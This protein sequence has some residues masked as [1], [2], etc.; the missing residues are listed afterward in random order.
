MLP[1][2]LGDFVGEPF[3][4]AS[5][6]PGP[7]RHLGMGESTFPRPWM[8]HIKAYLAPGAPKKLVFFFTWIDGWRVELTRHLGTFGDFKKMDTVSDFKDYILYENINEMCMVLSQDLAYN[9]L[10]E[11]LNSTV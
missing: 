7:A 2:F 4:P 3:F 10:I 8:L 11:L 9:T 6:Q 5:T 1:L